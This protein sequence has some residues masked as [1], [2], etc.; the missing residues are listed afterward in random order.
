[1][2]F[3]FIYFEYFDLRVRSKVMSDEKNNCPIKNIFNFWP[4]KM[5]KMQS[6]QPKISLCVFLCKNAISFRSIPP[7]ICTY[8]SHPTWPPWPDTLVKIHKINKNKYH[9]NK[10]AFTAFIAKQF[11]LFRHFFIICRSFYFFIRILKM[12]N[13]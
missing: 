7:M 8:S 13:R 5:F 3:D 2:I 10:T 6:T 1:M 9:V 11:W 4:L 12:G